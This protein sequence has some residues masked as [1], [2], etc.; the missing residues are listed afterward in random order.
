[1]S[2]GEE[3]GVGKGTREAQG[4]ALEGIL[5]LSRPTSLRDPPAKLWPRSSQNSL[6]EKRREKGIPYFRNSEGSEE[7]A[8]HVLL[9]K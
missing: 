6:K 2:S 5:V 8:S 4:I 3:G 1:M 9:Y 7:K